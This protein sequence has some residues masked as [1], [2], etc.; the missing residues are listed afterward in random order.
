MDF[1]EL[2]ELTQ[3]DRTHGKMHCCPPINP[4]L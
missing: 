1:T 3:K 4:H 2:A